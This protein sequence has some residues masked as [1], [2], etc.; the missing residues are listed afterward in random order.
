MALE[1]NI[2]KKTCIDWCSFL[3]EVCAH[4]VLRT[5]DG[6]LG[7]PGKVVEIDEA[8]IGRSKYNRGR[9]IEGSWIFG[10]IERGTKKC[11][12][13]PVASRDAVT[14]LTLIREN[15]EPGTTIISDCW[16][17]YSRLSNE[18]FQHFTVNH[19]YNF[20]DP[21]TNAHT[22]NIERLWREVRSSVPRYGN[23]KHHL[24]GHL[25]EFIFR[26]KNPDYVNRIHEIFIAIG[27]LYDGSPLPAAEDDSASDSDVDSSVE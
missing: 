25:A 11:F 7:G 10:G 27:K 13:C 16:K 19:S 4:Y 22:Q 12:L 9:R 24:H 6:K 15:I 8:K 26:Y 18:D 5:R 14:L 3:R 1:L 17:A 23:R 20:V 21:E 2:C